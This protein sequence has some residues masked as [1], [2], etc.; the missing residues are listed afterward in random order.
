MNLTTEQTP[1]PVALDLSVYAIFA[2]AI[3]PPVAILNEASSMF[4]R[5]HYCVCQVNN[6]RLIAELC[7]DHESENVQA[8]A[9]V[10]SNQLSPLEDLLNRICA[11]ATPERSEE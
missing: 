1:K 8:L 10:F 3:S 4:S 9:G 6:M 5:L 11:D 7:S 2:P